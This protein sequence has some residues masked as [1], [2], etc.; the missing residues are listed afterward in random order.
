MVCVNLN[1]ILIEA[2]KQRYAVGAFN[3]FNHL[4]ARAVIHG[5]EELK[6]PLIL[7]TSASTVK[8]YGATELA[9]ISFMNE[10]IL[11]IFDVK[12]DALNP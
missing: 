3:I 4:T 2:R 8:F 11:E 9:S 1:H 7:Q 12:I 6:S 5:A 10:S